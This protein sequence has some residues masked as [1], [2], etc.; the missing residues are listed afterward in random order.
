M[1]RLLLVALQ[2]ATAITATNARA[3]PR[4]AIELHDIDP[5]T[6][7][8][9]PRGEEPN[10]SWP[11]LMRRLTDL[12]TCPELY[13]DWKRLN[14]SM[15]QKRCGALEIV[16]LRMHSTT[17]ALTEAVPRKSGA[18]SVLKERVK[19]IKEAG[20]KL[21]GKSSS[22]SPENRCS[23][24]KYSQKEFKSFM[25]GMAKQFTLFF[26][27][28]CL[29]DLENNEDLAEYTLSA[30]GFLQ[31][32]SHF[33]NR[34]LTTGLS[35]INCDQDFL[36]DEEFMQ[37]VAS[38]VRQVSGHAKEGRVWTPDIFHAAFT[39]LK[40]ACS[41]QMLEPEPEKAWQSFRDFS[42]HC[43]KKIEGELGNKTTNPSSRAKALAKECEQFESAQDVKAT[44]H[45]AALLQLF[46]DLETKAEFKQTSCKPLLS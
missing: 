35:D 8:L 3:Q 26:Q 30:Q 22:K 42:P 29:F 2:L 1:V 36:C 19:S 6:P 40:L 25:I 18:A 28:P 37:I 32:L 21:T 44:R 27:Q 24:S 11:C 45:F 33:L 13:E 39:S 9:C 16:F 23:N 38:G 14:T 5:V 10:P 46:N 41:S 7:V 17:M 31:G 20:K 34:T 15:L 4:R 12:N 43:A